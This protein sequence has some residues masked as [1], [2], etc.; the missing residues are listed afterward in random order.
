MARGGATNSNAGVGNGGTRVGGSNGGNRFVNLEISNSDC[1]PAEYYNSPYFLNNGD[2]PV[3]GMNAN[4]FGSFKGK[5]DRPLCT[6]C[7]IVG[8]VVDK[9]YKLHGYPPGYK[10]NNR[11]SH[12]KPAANQAS[13]AS[14]SSEDPFAMS[15][16]SSNQCQQLIALLSSHLQQNSSQSSG[17]PLVSYFTSI[18]ST[19]LID[20]WI[21]DTGATHYVCHTLH[22]FESFVS[23]SVSDVILPNGQTAPIIKIG[24]VRLSSHIILYNVLFVPSFKYNLLSVSSL[25]KSL[26]CCLMFSATSCMIRD[27]NHGTKIG[28]GKRL[29]NLYYLDLQDFSN[30]SNHRGP[31]RSSSS[32]SDGTTCIAP[33]RGILGL[34]VPKP[35]P[36]RL[37]EDPN[38]CLPGRPEPDPTI[39]YLLRYKRKSSLSISRGNTIQIYP[40]LLLANNA[41]VDIQDMAELERRAFRVQH[42]TRDSTR[43][44]IFWTRPRRWVGQEHG[45]FT[46]SPGT[47]LERAMIDQNI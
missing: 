1:S 23:S 12:S 47:N 33:P 24:T 22:S 7:G 39:E 19:I 28:M 35:D 10:F 26:S 8:H 3:F 43:S 34:L 42:A 27:L 9:C 11:F 45:L 13:I 15:S 25:T 32:P 16:L 4:P 41:A 46:V 30:S 14:D 36:Y 20:A 44:F 18:H 40:F 17:E 5:R 2:H 31:I 6:H 37:I 38:E 21:L 29:G